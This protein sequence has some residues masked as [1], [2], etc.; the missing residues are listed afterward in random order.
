MHVHTHTSSSP[1]PAARSL[2]TPLTLA[3]IQHTA[4]SSR[5]C[6]HPSRPRPCPAHLNETAAWCVCAHS[7]L[8]ECDWVGGWVGV[9]VE[10]SELE[11]N[12]C[13]GFRVR[14]FLLPPA[15]P[16]MPTTDTPQCLRHAASVCGTT[17]AMDLWKCALLDTHLLSTARTLCTRT[18]G[19]APLP[20]PT[21]YTL[22]G[23]KGGPMYTIGLGGE[24]GGPMYTC[25]V[26]TDCTGWLGRRASIWTGRGEGRRT[27][28]RIQW[29]KPTNQSGQ[30]R[31]PE[32]ACEEPG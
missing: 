24:K 28:N 26:G 23:E 2:P 5:S 10:L 29:D 9:Q 22:G 30:H 8:R 20:Q 21:M 7:R 17:H 11:R 4:H 3:P 16:V 12:L 14:I 6:R 15:P 31:L 18:H 19:P 25:K 13:D 27:R 32:T 1:E